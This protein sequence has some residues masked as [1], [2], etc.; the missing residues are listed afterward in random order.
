M[1]IG[2]VFASHYQCP[3]TVL[4]TSG[5]VTSKL[6]SL[7]CLLSVVV[8]CVVYR[9]CSKGV[10]SERG[11]VAS[12]SLSLFSLLSVVVVCVVSVAYWCYIRKSFCSI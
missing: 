4:I 5:S 6:V 8:V 11:S 1:V 2:G 9:T 12:E 10:M 3:I 7:F